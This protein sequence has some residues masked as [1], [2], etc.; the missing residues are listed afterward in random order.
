MKHTKLT[1]LFLTLC[2]TAGLT[3]CAGK[4][5]NSVASDNT[6]SVTTDD[7]KSSDTP[8]DTPDTAADTSPDTK[9]DIK[10]AT[11]DTNRFEDI[12]G[13]AYLPDSPAKSISEA[14][15]SE[16][17]A[18]S[19]YTLIDDETPD[20]LPGDISLPEQ[21]EPPA[22]GQLTAAEWNDNDNWGFFSNLING[23]KISFPTFGIDPRYRTRVEVKAPDGT[24]VTNAT[25]RLYSDH[26]TEDDLLWTAVTDKHGVCYL[27]ATSQSQ[28][29]IIQIES[30]GKKQTTSPDVDTAP[31]VPSGNTQQENLVTRLDDLTVTFDGN[32]TAYNKTDIM[33]IVDATGSMSDEMAFLQSEFT[34]IT[35]NIDAPD[36]RY[37]V[38]FYRDEG[39][40]Y[41]TKCSEFTA[42]TAKIQTLLNRESAEGGGDTPEAVA[43][44]LKESFESN[45]WRDDAVKL[46]FLIFDAPPHEGKEQML[47]QAIKTAAAKGIRL[48]PV[49][50]SNSER[51][52]ELFGRAVA[53]TTGGTYLFL[54]DDS[55]IGDSHLEPIV[56]EYKVE[57]LYDLILRV[58]AS[59]C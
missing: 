13:E 7:K 35:K 16:K 44:I 31:T 47:Q 54:T 14:R 8:K 27:F 46:A 29:H 39:D 17:P 11:P 40:D 59:Y 5:N 50:S 20:A 56:G 30:N 49:V 51:D 52:T 12:A 1:A 6:P 9:T 41:V 48:I 24:P 36:A 25:V 23:K 15:P 21:Q 55:G 34:A 45:G 33:F 32:G 42:D 10:S 2:M 3:A 57:K 53:I 18:T 19:D 26:E 4:E 43:E 38:N 28:G 22:P 58:I 37:A